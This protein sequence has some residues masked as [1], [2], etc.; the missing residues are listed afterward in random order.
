MHHKISM[1]LGAVIALAMVPSA[2]AQ[3]APQ[4]APPPA[5]PVSAAMITLAQA[6]R[7]AQNTLTACA[8]KQE[9]AAVS[10]TDA[11]GNLRVAL[12]ADGLNPVGLRTAPLKST[13]VM[14]FRQS[15]RVLGERLEKDA[16]FRDGPGK[17]PRYFF[18]PGALPLYRGGQFIG[19]LAVGGGH[20]KDEA[21]ALEALAKEPDLK[22]AP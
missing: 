19:V 10:I 2:Q 17:D 18:H 4:S 14:Q 3:T 12:S 16:A 20:D 5:K 11:D 21:C 6:V 9:T 8:A 13:T 15:T 22:V 7:I 1:A